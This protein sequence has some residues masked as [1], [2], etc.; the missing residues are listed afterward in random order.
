[1]V[2]IVVGLIVIIW[3]TQW[4]RAKARTEAIQKVAEAQ[5]YVF[6]PRADDFGV[7]AADLDLFKKGRSHKLKNMMSGKG[8]LS[9]AH[10][11]DYEYTTGYGRSTRR[12]RQTVVAFELDHDRL[13]S[14]ALQ[15]RTF[16]KKVGKFFGGRSIALEAFP[17]FSKVYLLTGEQEHVIRRLFEGNVAQQFEREE[18]C[19]VEGNGRWLITYRTNRRVE[20]AE[21]PEHIQ[22]TQRMR[23]LFQEPSRRLG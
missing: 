1:V 19:C 13:P 15:P 9:G 6:T 23:T 18:P 14:F 11:F 22:Q 4:L 8:P 20:P 12:W 5:G 17:E 16:W 10:A 3:T 2:G 7:T 21:I